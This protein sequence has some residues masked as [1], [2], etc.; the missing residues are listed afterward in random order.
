MLNQRRR[1]NG[2]AGRRRYV[3]SIRARLMVLAA[4]A[5]LPLLV[6]RVR[7]IES[8]RAEQIEAA[9]KQ[10]LML[11]RQGM[12]AQN[13][14]IVSVR[15]FLQVAASA[16]GLMTVRGERCDGFLADTVKQAAWLKSLSFVEPGGKIVCSSN[17][18]V[19]GADI[20]HLPHF[21][22]AMRTGE[23][24]ISNYFVGKVTGP[25]LFTA[26]PHR[27]LDGS[28]D[29]LVSAPLQLSWFTQVASALA[30]SFAADV[31]VVDGS[32]TVLAREPSHE[33]W[34]GRRFADQ[35]VIRAMLAAPEGA[36]TGEG[37]DGVHR[38]FGFVE[39]PGTDARLAV[40]LDESEVLR[41]VNREIMTSIAELGLVTAVVLFG[42]WFGGERL[43]VRPIRSLTRM[44]QRIGRGE[45]RARATEFPWAPEFVPL[46]AA[47]DDM[48]AQL[49]DR[50]QKLRASNGELR[51]LAYIDALTGIANRR[52]FNARLS[53]E[54]QLAAELQRPIAVLVVDV[55]H[56]KLL[57]DHYGHVRGDACLRE[58]S[59]VLVACTRVTSNAGTHA[60]GVAG[61]PSLRK[62]LR[63]ETD[64]TA[65]YGGEEF[66]VLLQ[67][68]D[69]SIAMKVAERLRRA[70]EDLRMVHAKAPSGFVTISVGVASMV[71]G[72][73]DSAQRLVETA[74]A[75]LYEA[76]RRGRNVVV[77]H[78]ERVLSAAS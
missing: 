43:F 16:H 31:M 27:G 59:A 44:A 35:P 9:S 74:D 40:G 52:A 4:I 78:S 75:G 28:I 1:P 54:W 33:N 12:A 11:A 62:F 2:E 5:I 56:F 23:F 64:F 37:V 3:L 47:L 60:V 14:T 32:G 76:K 66:A 46:A 30:T 50:E 67:G 19:I 49:V 72:K 45:Y 51:E 69:L 7:Q 8:D 22:R 73:G 34:V 17:T 26:L 13:E 15:A 42:I 58:L 24:A 21:T 68:A 39:L 57:N 6:D 36:V 48:A 25:T 77:A 63:R 70:V 41:R 53:T 71:P 18:D 20:S 29:V 61:P 10:A 65:R 38:V 55:D